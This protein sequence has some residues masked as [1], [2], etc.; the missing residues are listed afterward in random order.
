[1]HYCDST[2]VIEMGMCI[3]VSLVSVRRPSCMSNRNLMVMLGCTLHNH[4]LDAVAT[5]AIRAGELGQ[6][7]L[8]LSLLILVDRG[9]TTG[10]IASA[11]ENL[12]T[13]DANW[14]SLWSISNVA[15][16]T[17]ALIFICLALL[18]QCLLIEE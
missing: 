14:S 16:D 12:K 3:D 5:E 8:G 7:P 17:A 11:L 9:D 15:D 6:D 13:L 1:M 2:S 10:V 4:T 18:I